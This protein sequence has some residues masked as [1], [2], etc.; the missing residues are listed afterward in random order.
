MSA[1]IVF[2][3]IGQRRLETLGGE[4]SASYGR[5]PLT[6]CQ[7]LRGAVS[8]RRPTGAHRSP[9]SAMDEDSA[10]AG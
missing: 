1:E 9:R 6:S 4:Q 7:L 2:E 5:S 10:L 3:V 8:N